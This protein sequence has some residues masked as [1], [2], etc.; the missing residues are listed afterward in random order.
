MTEAAVE[1][2]LCAECGADIRDEAL[3]CYNCGS[4]VVAEDQADGGISDAW[5]S[6]AI[7]KN[8][9]SETDSIESAKEE[10][11]ETDDIDEPGASEESGKD[12]EPKAK[13]KTKIRRK[14][15]MRSAATL[16]KNSPKPLPLRKVEV[17]WEENENSPNLWFIIASVVIVVIV[18]VLFYLSRVLR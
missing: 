13:P 14:P 17:V 9:D 12:F 8:E 11:V 4:A 10:I 16:R 1:N 18:G 5:F 7:V 15:K 2:N 6:E 3:F